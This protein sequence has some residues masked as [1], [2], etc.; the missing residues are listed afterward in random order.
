MASALTGGGATYG[1]TMFAGVRGADACAAADVDPAGG[2]ADVCGRAS[3]TTSAAGTVAC[4]H[5]ATPTPATIASATVTAAARRQ[6][7]VRRRLDAMSVE[8]ADQPCRRHARLHGR[9]WRARDAVA[10][11]DTAGNLLARVGV[12]VV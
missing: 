2:G 1:T 3:T 9:V 6:S 8:D 7:P 5:Q 4:A 11:P 10:C 12:A